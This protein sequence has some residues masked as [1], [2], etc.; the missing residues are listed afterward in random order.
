MQKKRVH[1][2]VSGIV[3]GV[4]FRESTRLKAEELMI[5]GWVKN[6]PDRTVEI[7]AEGMEPNL[8][9]FVEWCHEGPPKAVVNSVAETAQDYRGEFDSFNIVF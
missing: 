1:L 7:V 4:W 6:R 3:Q 8:K 5:K 9:K 2:I